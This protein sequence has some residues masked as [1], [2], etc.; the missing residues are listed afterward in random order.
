M[1]GI[2]DPEKSGIAAAPRAEAS[3]ITGAW[4]KVDLP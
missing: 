2:R 3:L 4:E 1:A